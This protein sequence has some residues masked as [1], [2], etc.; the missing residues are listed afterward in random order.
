MNPDTDKLIRLLIVD[1]SLHQAEIITSALRSAGLHVLAEFAEDSAEM[2]NIVTTKALDLVLFSLELPD[3]TL[4]Q[5]QNLI[6]ECGR[7]LYTIGLAQ[8]IN[9]EM[10]IAAMKLGAQDVVST[11]SL[12]R[13]ALVVRREAG[14]IKTWRQTVKYEKD[15]HESEKRCQ[16]LLASS[17]DAVAYVHEGMHIYA[18]EAY[19]ELFGN[20]DFDELEGMPL[21]DMVE[22]AQQDELKQFLRNFSQNKNTT[23]ELKL[24]LI[25]DSGESIDALLEFSRASYESESCT[26]ILIRSRADT[27]ELEQQ[28]NYMRQHDL[29]TGLYN[30]Q[31]FLDDL[32][33]RIDNAA[34]GA[35]HS[36]FLYIS[37][38]NFHG[39]RTNI[40]ISG[41]DILVNDI[42]KIL[43]QQYVAN[44]LIAR[45]GAHSFSI[46]C[47]GKEKSIIE[48]NAK[49]LIKQVE[50]HISETGQQSISCTCSIAVYSIDENTHANPNEI[51]SRV[52][53]TIDKIQSAGGNKVM[54]YVPVAGEMSQ[55]EEDGEIVRHIKAA[56][57]K[58]T[59]TPLFQPIVS[60][61]GVSGERYEITPRIETEDGK[62]LY[63]SDYQAAA[64]RT[65]MAGAL[66]RWA[67]ISAIKQISLA[68]Q[69]DRKID[70]F[71]ALSGDG[72]QDPTLPR[73][74]SARIQSAKVPGEQ[75]VFSISE[76]HALNHL[77][78]VKALFKSLKEL[79][80]QVVLDDFGTG[81]NPFQ[82][83]KHIQPDF[84]RINNAYVEGLASN[85]QNQ[86]SIRDITSQAATMEILSILPGVSDAGMLSVLWK[87]GADFVQGEFLQAPAE[88]LNY[89]FSSMSS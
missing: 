8:K 26:Q 35:P 73:W 64:E 49:T 47:S 55:Q 16:S 54:F 23:N 88:A 32:Q 5:M 30:R 75:L 86:D 87:V 58:N 38:D 45:F 83:V 40:G 37:I 33:Q 62:Q 31:F 7:H 80:C 72:L 20:T 52:D 70:I 19:L 50:Q 25:H 65:G 79:H 82:L 48:A 59:I 89:D 53:R 11:A 2:K 43:K 21:I 17:K 29:I 18:N 51:I 13:L 76:A 57:A 34:N 85:T 66:D 10:A 69:S 84:L 39:I 27:T 60:I 61:N 78:A 67:I 12:E 1:E 77:K 71:I 74:I 9:E 28:I 4:Q 44:E 68:S 3:F 15:L 36:F 46:I 6:R 63:K 14:N 42:A 81:L 22:P 24:K 41:C 56:I